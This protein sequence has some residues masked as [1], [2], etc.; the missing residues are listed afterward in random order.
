RTVT[1]YVMIRGKDGVESVV[2]EA[3]ILTEKRLH[4]VL[5]ENP[6]LLPTDDLDMESTVVVGR[7]S[8]LE[9]GYADL[10]L[11]DSSGALCLVEVK[12]EG[13][14]DTRRVV[15]QLLEYASTLWQMTTEDFEGDVLR[16]Y[17]QQLGLSG[18]VPDLAT[19]VYEHV[20]KPSSEP[21]DP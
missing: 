8:G 7:E 4:D 6:E 3:E 12:K 21:E 13:N 20:A 17:V 1:R 18:E 19:Y 2:Q 9:S 11:A 14:P 5:T 15:A 10:V 16:P